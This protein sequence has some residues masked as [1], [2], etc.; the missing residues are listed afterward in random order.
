MLLRVLSAGGRYSTQIRRAL[1]LFVRFPIFVDMIRGGIP[2]WAQLNL[3]CLSELQRAVCEGGLWRQQQGTT[4]L[5]DSCSLADC[6]HNAKQP[7]SVVCGSAAN[8]VDIYRSL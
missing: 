3:R 7:L 6:A 8:F 5:M 4:V 2:K 1:Y